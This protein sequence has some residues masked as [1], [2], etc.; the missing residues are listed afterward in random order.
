MLAS[1]LALFEHLAYLGSLGLSNTLLLLCFWL[2]LG[3]SDFAATPLAFSLDSPASAWYCTLGPDMLLMLRSWLP[4]GTSSTLLVF[5]ILLTL[6]GFPT[7]SLCFVL[8]HASTL[9]THDATLLVLLGALFFLLLF[10]THYTPTRSWC[11][12]LSFVLD[13]FGPLLMLR[14]WLR[15]RHSL[16]ATCWTFSWN[17]SRCSWRY[18]PPQLW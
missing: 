4:I 12:A 7:L 16:D 10:V 3:F 17:S 5:F 13:Q 1:W 15:L 8:G 11:Y 18:G 6:A 9:L 2:T 14:S